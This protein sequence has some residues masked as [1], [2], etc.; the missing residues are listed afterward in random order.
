MRGK[1]NTILR[2]EKVTVTSAGSD[3]SQADVVLEQYANKSRQD[4]GN[5]FAVHVR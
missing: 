1:S 2:R 4:A 5:D 3:V